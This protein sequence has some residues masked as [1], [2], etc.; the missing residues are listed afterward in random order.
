MDN[1]FYLEVV[2]QF[3]DVISTIQEVILSALI[4]QHAN[5]ITVMYL[6]ILPE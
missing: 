4:N 5:P 1:K 6:R 3:K 2:T